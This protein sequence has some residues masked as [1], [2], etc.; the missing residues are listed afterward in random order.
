MGKWSKFSF[1]DAYSPLSPWI[2]LSV[3]W[4]LVLLILYKSKNFPITPLPPAEEGDLK[5][6][7]ILKMGRVT[8]LTFQLL[9]DT[10]LYY[11]PHPCCFFPESQWG[12]RW[13]GSEEISPCLPIFLE[14]TRDSVIT[15]AE[16]CGSL[17]SFW[18]FGETIYFFKEILRI[19]IFRPVVK[20]LVVELRDCLNNVDVL[21]IHVVM[22]F[23]VNMFI[24]CGYYHLIYL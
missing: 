19:I 6:L 1:L 9:E 13:G 2:S 22:Y 16:V 4:D 11:L 3:L 17:T 14:V 10:I 7:S 20:L 21:V 24:K 23:I 18:V 5:R 8:S 12:C 15:A